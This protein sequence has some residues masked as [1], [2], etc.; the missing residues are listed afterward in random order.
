MPTPRFTRT[1]LMLLAL[2]GVWG[3]NF[4]VVKSAISGPDAPFTPLG[5]NALR[6]GVAAV[7]LLILLRGTGEPVPTSR[8]DWPA[9]VGLGL[10]GNL[11]YQVLFITGID[12]TSPANSSLI[13]AT[14]PVIVAMI[15]VALGLDRLTT[16]AWLG[17]VMSLAGIVVVVLGNGAS[18]ATDHITSSLLGDVLI[19]GAT[20]VWS[21]YTTLAAPLLQ[22]YSATMVTSL[23]LATAALPIILIALPDLSRLNWSRIPLTGWSAVLFSGMFALAAGYA[24]WNRGVKVI[25]GART[26]VYSNLTPIVAAVV[27]WIARGDAITVYHLIGG[28]IVLTG[29]HLTR[30]GKRARLVALPAEE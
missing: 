22:R 9:I 28:A 11:L 25:G 19:F 30:L 4:S 14:T 8:R 10:L 5:F 26:A 7:T 15:G 2:V 13:L 3:I 24:T 27:A 18:A 20:A 16:P 23:S 29:I 17:I 21:I 12:R 6:F 1:D